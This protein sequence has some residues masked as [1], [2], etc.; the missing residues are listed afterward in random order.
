MYTCKAGEDDRLVL[1]RKQDTAYIALRNLIFSDLR[2]G[3]VQESDITQIRV[4]R[5]LL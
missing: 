5:W 1:S 4:P 2:R 3:F